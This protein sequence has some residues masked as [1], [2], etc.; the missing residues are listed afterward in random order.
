MF[1]QVSHMNSCSILILTTVIAIGL[2]ASAVGIEKL[3]YTIE[4]HVGE[5]EIRNYASHLLA[6]MSV[7]EDFESA[8]NSGFRPLFRFITGQNANEEDISM[9]AP[10]LQAPDRQGWQVSFV[11]PR[12]YDSGSLPA[13]T[14]TR[15]RIVAVPGERLAAIQ[16]SGNW[17]K[18]RFEAFETRLVET[19]SKSEW[20]I[21]GNARWAR[22][23]PPFMPTFMRRNE[24]LLPV[25]KPCN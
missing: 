1:E 15:I 22:Y 8:G 14:D 6:T 2:P 21:C 7:N 9:T 19:I 13:P 24:V 12:Q 4:A 20:E 25:G 23:D 17:S 18:A 11:M 5:V 3:E 10:V 16:Y